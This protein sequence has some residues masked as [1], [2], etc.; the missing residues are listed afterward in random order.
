MN[1]PFFMRRRESADDLA[2]VLESSLD[3]NRSAFQLGT[4]RSPFEQLSDVIRY[5]AALA[6]IEDGD[7]VRMIE[8]AGRADLLL[9]PPN[10]IAVAAEDRGQNFDRDVASQ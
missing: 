4:K 1:N 2:R 8:L 7:D 6:D 10:P 9:K 5:R 3:W